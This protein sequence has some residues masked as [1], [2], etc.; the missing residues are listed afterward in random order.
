MTTSSRMSICTGQLCSRFTDFREMLYWGFLLICE[1]QIHVWLKS[2][3]NDGHFTWTHM[4]I[5]NFSL[6][7]RV[8]KSLQKQLQRKQKPHLLCYLHPFPRIH[9]AY[10]MIEELR[11]QQR[12]RNKTANGVRHDVVH[13]LPRRFWQ[14]KFCTVARYMHDCNYLPP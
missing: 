10:H 9:D 8:K 7:S 2:D 14:S 5:Y 12:D 3:K 1:K 11:E 4:Q 6:N 13:T